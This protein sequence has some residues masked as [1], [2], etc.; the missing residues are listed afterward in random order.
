MAETNRQ[1][2]YE[3]R[4]NRN[5]VYL[6]SSKKKMNNFLKKQEDKKFE[7]E[8][9]VS[10]EILKE[11]NLNPNEW[12]SNKAIIR[13]FRTTSHIGRTLTDTLEGINLKSCKIYKYDKDK[14]EKFKNS[15][16]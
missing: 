2:K 11:M 6:F 13:M 5:T 10:R 7:L 14:F 3:I 9:G 15:R 16:L 1:P 8:H 12:Y 4:L